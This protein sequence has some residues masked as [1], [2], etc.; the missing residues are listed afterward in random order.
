M[1]MNILNALCLDIDF[2]LAGTI[3]MIVN[4]LSALSRDSEFTVLVEL[5]AS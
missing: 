5:C 2:C 4:I 3:L 1:I